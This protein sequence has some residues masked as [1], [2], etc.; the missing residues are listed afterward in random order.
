MPIGTLPDPKNARDS[1]ARAFFMH[2]SRAQRGPVPAG[3][4]D[5]RPYAGFSTFDQRLNLLSVNSPVC[6]AKQGLIRALSAPSPLN[7]A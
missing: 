5:V 1:Q 7:S 3:P 2:A 6:I 4:A